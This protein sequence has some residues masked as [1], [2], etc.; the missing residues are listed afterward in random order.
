MPVWLH[1]ANV[2]ILF[3][4]QLHCPKDFI[5]TGAGQNQPALTRTAAGRS[6]KRQTA[7]SSDAERTYRSAS[8]QPMTASTTRVMKIRTRQPVTFLTRKR[9]STSAA[10]RAM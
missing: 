4:F 3:C 1:V 2:R 7:G 8:T 9:P 6:A 5:G 10:S